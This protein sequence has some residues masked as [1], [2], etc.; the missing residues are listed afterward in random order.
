M[1][2]L[3]SRPEGRVLE[4]IFCIL[5]MFSVENTSA[6][7]FYP[8]LICPDF[9]SATFC[10]ESCVPIGVVGFSF[11]N[12]KLTVDKREKTIN[13]R[14]RFD[15]C[16]I[17]SSNDW[18]CNT[19]QYDSKQQEFFGYEIIQMTRGILS[20]QSVG[21]DKSD[22]KWNEIFQC[23]RVRLRSQRNDDVD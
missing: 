10:S 15:D 22:M 19:I 7:D 11:E 21:Y 14:L 3:S 8:L 12:N 9:R 23:S 4:L 2:V 1:I 20:Q 6:N 16:K 13:K 17:Q 18:L 5:L